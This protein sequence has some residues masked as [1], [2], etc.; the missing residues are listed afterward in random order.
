MNLSLK[1][2]LQD[3]TLY[4]HQRN[5][6]TAEDAVLALEKPG[7]GNMNMVL[8]A[9][10]QQSKLILKQA[11]PYVQKY[12]DIPAPVERVA[13]EA[14]FYEFVASVQALDQFMPNLI[15]FDA[16]NRMLAVEDL[17]E[18]ADFTTLYQK[19]QSLSKAH[20][21]QIIFFLSVLHNTNL[22]AAQFP[23]NLA[24]RKLNYEHLFVYPYME[25]NGLNLDKI[26]EGL[27]AMAETYKTD[28]ALKKKM[29]LLGEVYLSEGKA[30]LHGDYYPGSWL[31]VNG[32]FKVIDPEFSYFGSAEYDLGILIAHLNMAQLPK[33][34]VMYIRSTYKCP[35]GFEW[36]LCMQFAGMEIMRRIIGL[37]QLPLDLTLGEREQL[38]SNA[39]DWVMNTE[40]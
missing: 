4:L 36:A 32:N 38:L 33:E 25:D 19:G 28:A 31:N 26:Q 23:D 37:A 29:Q 16:A 39:Y 5:W 10:T 35:A 34:Q 12:P 18:G 24:L 13:V 7:E 3:L 15:G 21:E 20:L 1:T 17:G 22:N 14:K 40:R 2:A 6:I 11:N 27:Q 30:L 9:K 8:R